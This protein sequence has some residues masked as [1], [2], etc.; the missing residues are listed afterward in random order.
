MFGLNNGIA[1]SVRGMPRK[2]ITSDNAQSFA[3]SRRIYSTAFNWSIVTNDERL[4][5][6]WHGPVNKDASAVTMTNRVNEIGIGSLNAVK[7]PM[8][9]KNTSDTNTRRQALRRVRHNGSMF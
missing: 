8:S 3:I 1:Q 4:M 7:Q 6:K 2:D 5:K 9:F